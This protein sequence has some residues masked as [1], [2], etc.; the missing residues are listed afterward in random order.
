M[1]DHYHKFTD[2]KDL[3]SYISFVM[4]LNITLDEKY[5]VIN[6]KPSTELELSL[7]SFKN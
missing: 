2:K 5:R 3:L 6:F 4:S 1:D 7:V